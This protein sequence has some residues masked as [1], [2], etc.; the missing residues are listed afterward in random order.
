LFLPLRFRGTNEVNRSRSIR[1]DKRIRKI[2]TLPQKKKKR[3][4]LTS[5]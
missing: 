3:Y 2:K 4:L 1:Q 5:K